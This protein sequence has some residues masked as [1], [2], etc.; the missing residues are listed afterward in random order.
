MIDLTPACRRMTEVLAGIADDQLTGPTPCAEYT[1]KDLVE[2]VDQVSQGFVAIARK[3]PDA[4][5]TDAGD[6]GAAWRDDVA[7]HVPALGEAWDDPAAWQGSA[8]VP[9][10]EL[11]SEQWGK[12]AFTEMVVHGWDLAKA[13]GQTYDLPEPTLRAC[14]DH[15]TVFVPNAPIPELWGQTV[16]LPADAPLLDRVVAVTG[17][18][19]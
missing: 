9:G 13:T 8:S 1:V 7:G 5:D 14:L 2:H 3:D 6:L 12:I 11:S 4:A 16:T 15:V 10:L 18:Q 17:R 19:P